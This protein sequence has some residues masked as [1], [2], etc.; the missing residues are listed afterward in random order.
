MELWDIT[1]PYVLKKNALL[2]NEEVFFVCVD[3]GCGHLTS[4]PVTQSFWQG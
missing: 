1:I 2:C 4:I 3:N